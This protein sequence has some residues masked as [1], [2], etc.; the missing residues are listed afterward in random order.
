MLVIQSA[1]QVIWLILVLFLTVLF[2]MT[3]I[4]VWFAV[5]NRR[6]NKHLAPD[7]RNHNLSEI[8]WIITPTLITLFMFYILG[9]ERI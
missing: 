9:L 3:V 2:A 6:N 1:D 7:F 8:M 4:L 5:K